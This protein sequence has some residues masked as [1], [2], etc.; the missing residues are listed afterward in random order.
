MQTNGINTVITILLLMAVGLLM[1]KRNVIDNKTEKSLAKIIQNYCVPALMIYNVTKSFTTEFL[2]KYKLSILAV[3]SSYV[4]MFILSFIIIKIFSINKDNQGIFTAMFS[5]SN[6]IFIGVPIITGVFGDAGIPY[7][8]LYYL[9]NTF[10]FWSIG[11]YFIG[12]DKGRKL[13]SLESL[14]KFF[15]PG[16]ISFFIAMLLLYFKITLPD[17]L[18]KSA[19]YLSSMVTPLSTLYMGSVIGDI[20]FK[21]LHYIKDTILVLLG[22]FIIAPLIMLTIMKYFNFDT[23][24]TRVFII[25]SSLPVMTNVSVTA[26]LYGKDTKYAAFMTT[27]TTVLYIFVLPFYF[28]FI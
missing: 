10:M 13:L 23:D 19:G 21:D 4:I 11:V 12:M 20:K 25:A 17:P 8:M 24:I 16:I 9:A 18:L 14:R 3:L 28:K 6:T 5:F 7:L 22:R 26:G 2:S 15:N 27:L 1:K